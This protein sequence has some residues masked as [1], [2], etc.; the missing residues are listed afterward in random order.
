[1]SKKSIIETVDQIINH[2]K[3][4][5]VIHLATE[6]TKLQQNI[7]TINDKPLVNFGSCSY[8]GLEFN[9]KLRN[10]AKNAID[11]YGTQFSSSRAY[12]SPKF[13]VDLEDK[14]TRIFGSP[15]I[16]TATTTLGHQ[17]ALPVLV[18]PNDV[19]IL[20]HQVHSSIQSAAQQLKAKKIPVELIRHNRMD[21]LEKRIL[22]L[23]GQYENIWYMADGIYSMYG[24]TT[25]IDEIYSLLDK[26]PSFNFYVDDAHAMSC[27]GE[28]GRGFVLA[29]RK[30]HERMVVATS[31]AKAFATGGGALIFPNKE[32][33]QK[34]RN[35]GG[36][37]ITSGPMQPSALGAANACA[38]IHLS[39]EIK[40]LQEDLQENIKY[41]TLLLK[42]YGLP[43]LSEKSSPIFFIA[44]G[45]PKIGYN[46]IER[47]MGE[48][49]YLNLGIFPAVPIK[50]TGVR[51]TITRLHT[52]EQIEAM[53]AAMAHHFHIAVEEES[54]SLEQI[55]KAFKIEQKTNHTQENSQKSNLKL[56]RLNSIEKID[57][58]EWDSIMAER[59]AF[60]SEYLSI[61]EQS[62]KGHQAK[63]NNWTFDY[64]LVRDENGKIVLATFTTL[65]LLKDDMLMPHYISNEVEQKRQD[66]PYY[67]TTKTLTVGSPISEGDHLY[68]NRS[69]KNWK[70]AL[71]IFMNELEKVQQEY[72]AENII[73]RD[74]KDN[75]DE[76]DAFMVDNGFFKT[77]MPDSGIIEKMD[78]NS[79]ED[80]YLALSTRS[81]RHFRE[82]IRR[83]EGEFNV[84]IVKNPTNSQ[85]QS[86][87]DLYLN[88]KKNSLDLNT[89]Q[90]PYAFFEAMIPSKNWEFIELSL[91]NDPNKKPVGV[92]FAYMTKDIYNGLIVGIDYEKNYEF[93]V[94][95]QC[96]YQVIKRG[97]AL[98]SKFL[99]LGFSAIVE[100]KKFGASVHGSCAYM[101]AK[102]N[103][104]ME[105]L[106]TI[107]GK[108][109]KKTDNYGINKRRILP[110]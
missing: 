30:I 22:E 59:G 47:L 103:F 8:L 37:L 84:E 68:L 75:D 35:C 82:N 19:V 83:F 76:L 81:K 72:N 24:D 92:V 102:D 64:F 73:I 104:N 32:M 71:L 15:T 95:R 79:E 56:E 50:N 52:F 67:L 86:Y 14:L 38:D 54:Y 4:R 94:Y 62:F 87:Y 74:L 45:L 91:K 108:D 107:S 58:N 20:D 39:G 31:F 40:E 27:F 3:D 70:K 65:A 12:V 80:F 96:M 97:K 61:L 42:K 11:D 55:Y 93:N 100:K 78:W 69:N 60:D 28:N 26:Y 85:L 1:M 49:F 110:I 88:V 2:A 29:D 89:F 109:E 77:S 13:Y 105:L 21:L 33:A 10:G 25:P 41:T 7:I 99:P 16:V 34:V 106:G 9:E 43:N 101:Q 6:D 23:K 48:G 66:D 17:A 36:T 51:F 44:V 63:E 57:S 5:G 53:V 98:N 46:L 18:G 90:L